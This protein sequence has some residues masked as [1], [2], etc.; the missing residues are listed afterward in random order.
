MKTKRYT[1]TRL[2][3][4]ATYILLN[5]TKEE[6]ETVW[7]NSYLHVLGFT[8]K[9]QAYLKETKAQIQLP[10]ISKVSK[11]KPRNAFVRY[12]RQS[13]IPNGRF[14]F[15]RTKFWSVSLRF[16][17]IPKKYLT[18]SVSQYNKQGIRY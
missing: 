18:K 17:Q 2:Q 9:G 8:P 12:S 3:R 7:Q 14:F 5:M 11:R 4:L 10:V 16:R 13:T 1:W 15:K 6:V